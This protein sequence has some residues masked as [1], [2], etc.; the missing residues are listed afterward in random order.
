MASNYYGRC[1]KIRCLFAAKKAAISSFLFS[2]RGQRWGLMTN[3]IASEITDCPL[4][5]QPP[6]TTYESLDNVLT[7]L[8]WFAC[9]VPKR[10]RLFQIARVEA[11]R[12]G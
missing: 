3:A 9:A 1:S 6:L 5:A 10:L 8:E 11:L 12:T 7:S 2:R 4:G